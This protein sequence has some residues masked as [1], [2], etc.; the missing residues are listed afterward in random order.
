MS[1][2]GTEGLGCTLQGAWCRCS[3]LRSSRGIYEGV[4]LRVEKKASR[5]KHILDPKPRTQ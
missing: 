1:I 5:L 2:R 3:G 4:E